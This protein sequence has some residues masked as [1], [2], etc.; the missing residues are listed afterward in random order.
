MSR[1]I[2][3]STG[4]SRKSTNWKKES[5]LWS[6]FVDRLKI[7][8]K[9]TETLEE[10]MKLPKAKQDDLKDVGGFVA[11]E[12]KDGK[13]KNTNIVSR[14]VVTLDL[15]NIE[16]G[17]T[18]DVLKRLNSLGITYAVY[19]TRKHSEY[20]PRLRVL[21]L[22]DRSMSSDE[23][24]PVARKLGSYIGISM[25]DPT[26]FEVARLMFWPSC[27]SDSR[28]I[29]QFE[30]KALVSVD[31]ILKQYKDW[32]DYT[33]W[34]QVP[35]QE[36]IIVG[37][38]KKQE[39]PLDKKGVIGAFCK[40]YTIQEAVEK[41][42]PDVY[43]ATDMKD[44][45]TY[46]AGS[47]ANGAVIYD[48]IFLY[49]HHATDPAGQKL[50]NA[51][52][53]VRIHMFGDLDYETKEGTPVNKLPSFV[54]MNKFCRGISE[55]STILNQERY[56]KAQ[57][58][59]AEVSEDVDVLPS[60]EVE[61]INLEWMSKLTENSNGNVE[62]SIANIVHVL[63]NDPQLKGK[64][65]LDEFANRGIVMGS[66]PW[67]KASSK[68]YYEEVDDSSLRSY[69]EKVYKLSGEKK[70]SDAL[71]IISHRNKIN[72]VKA[73]LQSLKWDGVERLETL[74]VEYLGTEDNDYTRSIMKVSLSAAVA[75][76]CEGA[77]KYDYMPIFTGKQ[78]IGKSTF[79]SILGKEWFS[80]SLQHFEGKEAAEMI[81]GTW[82]NE[83]GELTGLSRSE[84]NL[85][86]QFLSKQDDIY[87]EA[88]GR[89]T[90]RYPRRC[91]FF[92]TSNDWEFLKDKTGNRRF[93]PIEVGRYKATKSIW[94]DLPGE[95]DQIWA[96]AYNNYYTKGQR[97]M[98]EGKALVI[99]EEMQ[100]QHTEGS[101]KEGM[102]KDFLDKRVPSDWHKWDLG[103]RRMFWSGSAAKEGLD[104]VE[105]DRVCVLEV[106]VE[107]FSGDPK[108]I[109]KTDA[110]EINKILEGLPDWERKNSM[111]TGAYGTQRGYVKK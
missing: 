85:V 88:Y 50:C 10:Y 79:L 6:E 26:T 98:L 68:R 36:K 89:R 62:K 74:L 106:Y 100:E 96:E 92:G 2:I 71:L 31:G 35:G 11:G 51:F 63:E 33:E 86:K 73:Y 82:I 5:M 43:E 84:T 13:R 39:N 67:N 103:R 49:S 111:K 109:R 105:R 21:I 72:G 91:I 28:Y 4:E 52:D 40:T 78:G 20:R 104:L 102:I 48:D 66:L 108:Y 18:Q 56:S 83:L 12:L 9:S 24:E 23:Y 65:V 16:A 8:S 25:C 7:P 15:D 64:L 32:S 46:I 101:T 47:T 27:S 99:S 60:E 94:D 3:I 55:V 29:Y 107:C 95:V 69:L 41:F 61:E 53:L 87:R 90:N 77:V 97:L 42:L 44:R 14:D 22:T 70:V 54:E 80:D 1:Q 110:I 59:F 38:L 58:D 30:N 75:R 17:K 19:S 93:W 34:P 57:D 45:L 76:A 81:Q 37:Q